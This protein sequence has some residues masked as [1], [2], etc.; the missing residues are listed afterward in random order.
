MKP[1]DLA[2]LGGGCAGLSL[3]REIARQETQSPSGR[4]VIVLEPRTRYENDRTWC[5]WSLANEAEDPL[6]TQRWPAWRFSH[7]ENQVVHRSAQAR[8]CL[9]NGGDFYCAALDNLERAATID[10]RLG[11]TVEGV[12]PSVGM[13]TVHTTVGDFAVS[14]IV[15]TRPP[16]TK[17]DTDALLFQAF[18]GVEIETDETLGD[19]HVA[20]LM[21]RL[22]SDGR[23]LCFDYVLSL[24][25]RRWLVEATR[26]S[27]DAENEER[28]SRDLQESLHRLIP[29][30]EFRCLRSEKGTIPMGSRRPEPTGSANWVQAGTVGGAVRPASGYAYRRIQKWAL[31]CARQFVATGNVVGHPPDSP[32]RRGMDSLF[33]HVIRNNPD[34]APEIFLRLAAGMQPDAMA[35]FM[36][37]QARVTDLI[38]VIKS[39]PK[40]PFLKQLFGRRRHSPSDLTV[41]D[42]AR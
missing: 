24:G 10:L 16:K 15:D 20:G 39:L 21:D 36:V 23:S 6:V 1:I 38:S 19:P 30:G 22:R 26:F 41:S 17:S 34:L 2:I 14:K 3:A 40:L 4:R 5:F 31:T 7:A 12:T 32:L 25:P 18:E 35:R 37:D 27:P 28:L 8:Y 9:I 42:K 13:F 11:V 33:L 29:T